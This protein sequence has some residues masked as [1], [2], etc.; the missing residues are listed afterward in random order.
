M[1]WPREGSRE[2]DEGIIISEPMDWCKSPTAIVPYRIWAYQRDAMNLA[3]AVRQTSDPTHVKGSIVLKSYG[4]EPGVGGGIISGTHNAECT[5][6][7]WSESVIAQSRNVVRHDDEWWMN[8]R[9]TWGR[10]TYI[11][12][13]GLYSTDTPQAISPLM[14]NPSS[15]AGGNSSPSALSDLESSLGPLPPNADQYQAFVGPPAIGAGGG[16]I[17]GGPPGALVGAAIGTAVVV[18]AGVAVV[19]HEGSRSSRPKE[20]PCVVAPYLSLR[21]VCGKACLDGQAHH[22]VPDYT[23]RYGS[24][25]EGE[26]GFKRI[27]GLASFQ[28]GMAICLQGN[29]KHDG[30]AHWEA[31]GADQLIADLGNNHPDTPAYPV[32]TA[33]IGEIMEVSKAQ[34][35]SVRKECAAQIEK[36]V[37]EEFANTNL[38][39]LGRTYPD[40]RFPP[41]TNTVPALSGQ[42]PTVH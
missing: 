40:S 5:P 39:T 25:I 18:I 12:D 23:K 29:A 26:L 1:T 36:G 34:T 15:Q 27:K 38:N 33:P 30:S 3:D 6:K 21:Y 8:H 16:A 11:K 19:I 2:I 4:D 31:H 28:N 14:S 13:T 35:I 20:C 41:S 17:V 7:T 24:R 10:L 32:G 22:I 37:S 42:S 9:N